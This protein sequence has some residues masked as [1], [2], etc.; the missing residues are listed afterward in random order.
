MNKQIDKPYTGNAALLYNGQ[1]S[2]V[3][4]QAEA[5]RQRILAYPD[6]VGPSKSGTTYYISYKGDDAN[7]GT[8][9]TTAWRTTDH[10]RD[11]PNPLKHGDVVLFERGGI[12]RRRFELTAGVSYA[13]YGEGPKPCI[14]GGPRNYNDPALWE[15][16]DIP[17]VWKV[18]TKGLGVGLEGRC[19]L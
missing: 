12:Y 2:S 5:M 3:D 18:E 1:H 19:L 15:K 11:D 6:K 16:S 14:Y 13:A 9:P 10:L 7:D 4:E 17:N 8:S